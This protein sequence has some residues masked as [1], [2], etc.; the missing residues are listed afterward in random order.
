M[1]GGRG[2]TLSDQEEA[3]KEVLKKK[4]SKLTKGINGGGRVEG[5]YHDGKTNI[6]KSCIPDHGLGGE[7]LEHCGRQGTIRLCEKG[8]GGK[9]K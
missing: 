8:F 2:L 1:G 4:K 6:L 9:K 3:K 5:N 7:G